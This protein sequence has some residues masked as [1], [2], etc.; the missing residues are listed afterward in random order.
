MPVN[1]IVAEPL[2]HPRPVE[3]AAAGRAGSPSSCGWS[4]STPSTAT[5]TRTSSP[6]VSGS[7]SASPGRWPSSRS[8]WCS[9]SRSPR[10]TS[11]VQAGVVNLL[12]DLQDRLGLAYL[13]I[14][15]DLSVVRHIS[16][17]VAVMYL[18]RVVET[19]TSRQGLRRADAP[20]HAGAAVRG[21]RGRPGAGAAARADH[22]HG[23]VPS[24]VN[25]PS[26]CRFRTR[27]WKA[28]DICAVEEPQLVDHGNGNLSLPLRRDQAVAER[29]SRVRWYTTVVDARDHRAQAA[30][31]ARVLGWQVF[32]ESD[33]E[34]VVIRLGRRGIAGLPFERV[35]PGLVSCPSRSRRPAR[36]GC[37]STSR[38]P[39]TPTT[40]RG[41]A[42]ARPR[43]PARRRRSGRRAVGGARRPRGQRVLRAHAS[44]ELTPELLSSRC[45]PSWGALRVL[46][47]SS[48]PSGR[49]APTRRARARRS[50]GR[51]RRRGRPA[52]GP[53]LIGGHEHVEVEAPA[54]RS[55]VGSICWNH[56]T[57][58]RPVR[59][60]SST[61]PSRARPLHVAQAR[62]PERAGRRPRRR[63]PGR[64]RRA[65]AGAAP[66]PRPTGP[67]SS[68]RCASSTSHCVTAPSGL[69][70][71]VNVTTSAA[72][73][74]SRGGGPSRRRPR[75]PGRR[76]GRRPR[77]RGPGRR[78]PACV[79]APR[80]TPGR[81]AS[82]RSSSAASSGRGRGR[83]AMAPR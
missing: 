72:A 60:C 46:T 45:G 16:D 33:D 19:G 8:C 49:R 56:N 38:R 50:P 65:P 29:S 52:P 69:L 28:Q 80:C 74:G 12:E 47:H 77:T 14:A 51:R 21:A 59:S 62:G 79:S 13:F 20:V 22:P 6:A 44:G 39:R 71:N 2:Q 23:D 35:P 27:C 82:C 53:G 26:G 61:Q 83:S 17:R 31:W 36:T 32:F 24:P 54:C 37:T 48:L 66:R 34:A 70:V 18:G 30:W 78:G 81:S 5:A 63:S 76:A 15:H 57:G 42:P 43:R 40:P 11:R 10:S 55:V 7:A 1:D 67:A 9:T 3:G 68:T 75:R 58:R 64:S 25:P 41:A 73:G 4:A